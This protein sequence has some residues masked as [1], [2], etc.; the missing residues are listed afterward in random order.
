[1]H[2]HRLG[3]GEID[4]RAGDD[5]IAAAGDK[6]RLAEGF[7]LEELG[8]RSDVFKVFGLRQELTES[9]RQ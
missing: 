3:A 9:S 4:A 2:R 8:L 6:A 1:M 5:L 7:S